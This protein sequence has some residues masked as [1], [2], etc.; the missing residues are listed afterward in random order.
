MQA[1]PKVV[2]FS[3]LWKN[4]PDVDAPCNKAFSNQCAIRVGAALAKSGVV[5]TQLVPK[6]R[7]CWF[8]DT[9]EGHVLAAAELAEGLNKKSVPGI[10]KAE[11]LT[12]TNFKS[13]ISGRSGIIYFE[14][15][16]Q[17]ETDKKGQ[18]TGD[19]IDLWNG[20]RITDWSSWIRIQMGIVIPGVWSDLE[21][22]Q[23]VIFWR[24]M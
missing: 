10:Q 12:P 22:S 13:K 21:A 19:H 14:N 3:N 4:Y 23:R 24:V 8:H 15:Y 20:S 17:R 7:H 18:M 1:K 5:T 16:W 9:N 2:K 6:A 11:S